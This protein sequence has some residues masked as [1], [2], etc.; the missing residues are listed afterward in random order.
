MSDLN[1]FRDALTD[2]Q[3]WNREEAEKKKK[4]LAARHLQMRKDAIAEFIRRH[5]LTAPAL[6]GGLSLNL[7]EVSITTRVT[8]WWNSDWYVQFVF[9]KGDRKELLDGPERFLSPVE[10]GLVLERLE[11]P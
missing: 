6:E 3:R 5:G 1:V 10:V 9:Q 2:V 8:S 7:D 11:K 4:D